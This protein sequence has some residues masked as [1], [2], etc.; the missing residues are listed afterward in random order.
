M[1]SFF[2]CPTNIILR[3]ACHAID[4]NLL[5]IYGYYGVNYLIN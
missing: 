1:T 2:Y 5:T 3:H 4:N